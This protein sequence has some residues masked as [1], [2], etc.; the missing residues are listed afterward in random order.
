MKT[1]A[2]FALWGAAGF[3]IGGAI[4]YAF[5]QAFYILAVA[6]FT[7]GLIGGASLGL[8]LKSWK[9]A[10]FF[11]LACSVGFL[12]GAALEFVF[13]GGRHLALFFTGA[14]QGAIGGA[15]LGLVLKDWRIAAVL[16]LSGAVGFGVSSQA[17]YGIGP[18]LVERGMLIVEGLVWGIVG[19]LSLRQII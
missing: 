3:G 8:A 16:A 14:I 1:I 4:G 10:A 11:A 9:R 5:W 18:W 19:I 7:L 2:K 15:S 6:L 13:L 17:L 12:I